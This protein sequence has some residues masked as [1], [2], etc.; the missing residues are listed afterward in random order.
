MILSPF[1]PLI[2]D[3]KRT[4]RVFGRKFQLECYLPKIQGGPSGISPLPPAIHRRFGRR[5]D[6]RPSRREGR[7]QRLDPHRATP[8]ASTL[9]RTARVTVARAVMPPP[10][11]HYAA[12][13]PARENLE[14]EAFESSDGRMGAL[15]PRGRRLALGLT[16]ESDPYLL[17]EPLSLASSSLYRRYRLGVVWM[18]RRSKGFNGGSR[19]TDWRVRLTCSPVS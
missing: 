12:F 13:Q 7:S 16:A 14:L 5:G 10:L 19:R 1:D 17:V 6:N 3:R 8:F 15:A 9:T 18:M 2:L 4:A 11:R